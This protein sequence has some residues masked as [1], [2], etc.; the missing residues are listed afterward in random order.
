MADIDDKVK[1][2][3]CSESNIS[4]ELSYNFPLVQKI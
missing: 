4:S 3:T 1:V 2:K